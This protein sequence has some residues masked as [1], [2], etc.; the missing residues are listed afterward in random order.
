MSLRKITKNGSINSHF[1]M[2]GIRRRRKMER[3]M[4]SP[5]NN[6]RMDFSCKK[7]LLEIPIHF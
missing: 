2:D 1:L 7:R 5:K 4:V 6:G 3:W